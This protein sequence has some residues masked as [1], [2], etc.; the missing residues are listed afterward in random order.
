[1]DPALLWGSRGFNPWVVGMLLGAG[2]S[3]GQSCHQKLPARGSQT[4]KKKSCSL[5][6][7]SPS[8]HSDRGA[9]VRG[10]VRAGEGD[11]LFGHWRQ[12]WEVAGVLEGGPLPPHH[13]EWDHSNDNQMQSGAGTPDS[14]MAAFLPTD[15]G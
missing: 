13:R 4:K 15:E 2:T 12:R 3:E 5:A 6:L 9:R 11:G 7:C 8:C 14:H 10:G 1:M